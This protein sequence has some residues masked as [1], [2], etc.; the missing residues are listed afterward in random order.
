[1]EM[2][3]WNEIKRKSIKLFLLIEVAA[4]GVEG[5]SFSVSPHKLADLS[6]VVSMKSLVDCHRCGTCL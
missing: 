3:A 4:Q 5:D 2:M 1:M 6:A